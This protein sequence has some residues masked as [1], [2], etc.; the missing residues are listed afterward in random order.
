MT[1][2]IEK[3]G[4]GNMWFWAG[5]YILLFSFFLFFLRKS[6]Y[7]YFAFFP[8]SVFWGAF[9]FFQIDNH[10]HKMSG[11]FLALDINQVYTASVKRTHRGLSVVTW[12]TQWKALDWWQ[13]K[14]RA[15]EV[16]KLK[17]ILLTKKKSQSHTYSMPQKTLNFIKSSM[18]TQLRTWNLNVF[19]QTN[20]KTHCD[21][22]RLLFVF[23]VVQL[24]HNLEKSHINSVSQAWENLYSDRL[25]L[26]FS[27]CRS[28][29]T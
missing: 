4:K 21:F 25:V 17:G 11:D 14:C 28:A 29:H 15:C 23:W 12:A 5:R 18:F 26:F 8:S 16:V 10:K 27:Q 19:T 3:E 9:F 7:F 1:G 13:N 22:S 2:M 6:C 24:A 20:C